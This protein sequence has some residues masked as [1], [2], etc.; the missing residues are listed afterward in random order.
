MEEEKKLEFMFVGIGLRVLDVMFCSLVE[1]NV[2]E[3]DI[4]SFFKLLI[5]IKHVI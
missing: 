1:I 2:S 4:V 3:E 5:P